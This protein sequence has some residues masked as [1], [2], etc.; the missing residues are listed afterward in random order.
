ME[1]GILL[2]TAVGVRMCTVVTEK[3]CDLK[4]PSRQCCDQRCHVAATP[5]VYILWRLDNKVLYK[6][7]ES[8]QG[9]V[10]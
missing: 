1:W 7:L 8:T 2:I 5:G 3:L 4:I 10:V 9:S 6:T